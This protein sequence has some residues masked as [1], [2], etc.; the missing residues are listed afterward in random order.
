MVAIL[1]DLWD[2]LEKEKASVLTSFS[3]EEIPDE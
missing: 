1:S 3:N 2:I